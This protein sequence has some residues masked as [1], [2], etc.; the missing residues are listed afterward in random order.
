MARK[1]NLYDLVL[2]REQRISAVK[3]FLLYGICAIIWFLILRRAVS[4]TYDDARFINPY[5]WSTYLKAWF[6][7]PSLIMG[8]LALCYLDSRLKIY[9]LGTIRITIGQ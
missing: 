2:T 5:N 3:Y 1:I 8:G 7:L 4:N 9:V 6:S